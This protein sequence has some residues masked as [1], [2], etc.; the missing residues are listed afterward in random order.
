MDHGLSTHIVPATLEKWTKT[1]F[2][3]TFKDKTQ[4]IFGN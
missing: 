4:K 1:I 2:K 3:I